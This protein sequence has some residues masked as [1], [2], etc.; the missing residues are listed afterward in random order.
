M[1]LPIIWTVLAVAVTV[2]IIMNGVFNWYFVAMI[3]FCMACVIFQWL[4]FAKKRY[5]KK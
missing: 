4:A 2:I 3:A 5:G 1:A